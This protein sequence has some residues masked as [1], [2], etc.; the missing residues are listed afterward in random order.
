MWCV[1]ECVCVCVSMSV[2][3]C[4]YRS[5]RGSQRDGLSGSGYWTAVVFVDF[6][7]VMITVYREKYFSIIAGLGHILSYLRIICTACKY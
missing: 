5:G 1:C 6:L 4:M 7:W 2:C 3:M